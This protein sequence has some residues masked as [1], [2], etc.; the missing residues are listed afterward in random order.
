[1]GIKVSIVEPGPFRT[2]FADSGLGAAS[3]HI[4][5]YDNTSGIF[6]SKIKAVNGNQEGDPYKAA[7][8]IKK[9]VY[10][11]NPTLRMPLG[12]TAISSIESKIKSV[13]SDLE[14]HRSTAI[15]AVF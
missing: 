12:K 10:S 5:D 9:L 1:L 6:S 7:Q 15:D 11:E 3:N 8:A 13:Q 14:A 4:A 2:K